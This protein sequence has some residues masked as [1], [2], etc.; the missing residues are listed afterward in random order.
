[1]RI[2]T[3]V[4]STRKNLIDGTPKQFRGQTSQNVRSK[5]KLKLESFGSKSV[6]NGRSKLSSR[7][8]TN[9]KY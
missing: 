3:A 5:Q 4:G 7:N 2:N 1:M 9:K 6:K 8:Q